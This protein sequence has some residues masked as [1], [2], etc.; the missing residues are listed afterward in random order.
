[1]VK[2]G[3][4]L[5][6][7]GPTAAITASAMLI[8]FAVF[9]SWALADDPAPRVGPMTAIT[10]A[11]GSAVIVSGELPSAHARDALFEVLAEAGDIAVIVSEV[12]IMP[13]VEAPDSITRLADALLAELDRVE[14][15]DD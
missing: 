7:R 11:D 14:E 5:S 2:L 9:A 4:R 1:M 10:S 13:Q 3:T 12:R 8:G 6:S 15:A